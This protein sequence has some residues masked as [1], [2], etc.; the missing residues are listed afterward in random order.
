M[1]YCQ[2]LNYKLVEPPGL[3]YVNIQNRVLSVNRIGI[4]VEYSNA[5]IP[6]EGIFLCLGFLMQ[7]GVILEL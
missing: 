5:S 6:R 7:P 1:M 4:W 3:N 2:D